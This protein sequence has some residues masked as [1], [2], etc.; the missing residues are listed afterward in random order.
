MFIPIKH[1]ERAW[2]AKLPREESLSISKKINRT[3]NG[4]QSMITDIMDPES[5]PSVQT[6]I[7]CRNGNGTRQECCIRKVWN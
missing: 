5:I 4:I 3:D 2:G 7:P 1:E 6:F